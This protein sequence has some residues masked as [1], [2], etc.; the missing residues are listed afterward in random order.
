MLLK[1]LAAMNGWRGAIVA[2]IE[3]G[4]TAE[5]EEVGS[6]VAGPGVTGPAADAAAAVTPSAQTARAVAGRAIRE[7]VIGLLKWLGAGRRPWS[8]GAAVC[9]PVRLRHRTGACIGAGRCEHRRVE[10][11][12]R[13][14]CGSAHPPSSAPAPPGRKPSRASRGRR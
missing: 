10:S 2:G 6:D 12:R 3:C 11:A 8:G 4:L 1:G 14:C 9:A 7:G 5:P 13:S